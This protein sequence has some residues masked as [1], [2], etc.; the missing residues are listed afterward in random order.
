MIIRITSQPI[1]KITTAAVPRPIA[2]DRLWTQRPFAY[3]S[4]A[5][6]SAAT[7][8]SKPAP[9]SIRPAISEKVEG[10]ANNRASQ[11]RTVR[12]TGTW[13]SANR[14]SAT[15]QGNALRAASSTVSWR[16]SCSQN[17]AAATAART[18]AAG[19]RPRA[20]NAAPTTPCHIKRR[21]IR[22][23]GSDAAT[24]LACVRTGNHGSRHPG[25]CSTGFSRVKVRRPRLK[26]ASGRAAV[27]TA[28]PASAASQTTRSAGLPTAMP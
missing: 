22:S 21:S 15:A 23:P 12:R 20:A 27:A 1:P 14:R 6:G 24:H 17:A 8:A 5:R 19:N 18:S 2:S 10:M 11:G 7:I 9:P 13:R 25:R 3:R 16:A 26:P 4:P 28:W